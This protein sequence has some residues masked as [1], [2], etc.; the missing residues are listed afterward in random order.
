MT[1]D[2]FINSD[3][4]G[5]WWQRHVADAKKQKIQMSFIN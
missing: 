4:Y 5:S 3:R 2:E 1:Y